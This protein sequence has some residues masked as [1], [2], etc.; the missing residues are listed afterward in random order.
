MVHA[1]WV[2]EGNLRGNVKKAGLNPCPG[3]SG[4]LLGAVSK[5]W[6]N[7]SGNCLAGRGGVR[8]RSPGSRK[9]PECEYLCQTSQL[10]P[11]HTDEL[12]L[13]EHHEIG[14]LQS[15]WLP[16]TVT[17]CLTHCTPAFK[18][19]FV[20]WVTT[21]VIQSRNQA[22]RPSPSPTVTQMPV[23]EAIHGP[24]K[25]SRTY[26]WPSICTAGLLCSSS[27]GQKRKQNQPPI[28]DC[29]LHKQLPCILSQEQNRMFSSFYF[30]H[31]SQDLVI[32]FSTSIKSW[33]FLSIISDSMD[34]DRL[35][36]LWF[37]FLE[38]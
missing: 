19:V 2:A 8:P 27:K 24:R 37:N 3:S 22:C 4:W 6:I 34:L 38:L 7:A 10:M 21:D 15:Q 17:L 25:H 12:H 26:S 14:R 1:V 23:W 30:L 11:W 13:D 33:I 9:H 36:S 5:W 31:A 32:Y 35:I 28:A 29:F 18:K 20:S 16:I